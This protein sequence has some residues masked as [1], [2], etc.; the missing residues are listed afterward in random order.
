MRYMIVYGNSLEC[1]LEPTFC[2]NSF[3]KHPCDECGFSFD[4]AK[5]QVLHYYETKLKTLK[6]LEEDNWSNY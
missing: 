3:C 2:T 4:E 1:S 6:E 5:I